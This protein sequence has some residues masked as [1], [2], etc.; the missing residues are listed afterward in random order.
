MW[1]YCAARCAQERNVN[2]NPLDLWSALF[3]NLPGPFA[4]V[5]FVL[6]MFLALAL[7]GLPILMM[8]RSEPDQLGGWLRERR[9]GLQRARE[10]GASTSELYLRAV[11]T[12]FDGI[13]TA[14]GQF[15]AWAALLMVMMQ[16]IVVVMRY[17]FAWGSIQM[18]ESIW[19]MHGILFMF[20]AAYTLLKDGHVR[21]DIFYRDASTHRKALI[22]LLGTLLF[23]LPVCAMT[24]YLS[25]SYVANSWAV[26][27]TST[28]GSG[29]PF[30]YLFKTVILVFAALLTLQSISLA[31]RSSMILAGKDVRDLIEH[32]EVA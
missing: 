6:S 23:L 29:L 17:V 16:F 12:L 27:E 10:F 30:I 19:Y 7:F 32:E 15:I 26:L 14:V 11:I 24:W 28:E 1:E 22:D 8:L 18:Q 3:A 25:W 9:A 31:L 2:L 21:V 5:V 20:G 4:F 13:S